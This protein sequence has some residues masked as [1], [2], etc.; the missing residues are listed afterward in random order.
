M[1]G[2]EKI[3]DR[4][5]RYVEGQKYEITWNLQGIKIKFIYSEQ[6]ACGKK[7][8]KQKTN[9]KKKQKNT[10][11]RRDEQDRTLE[12]LQGSQC[13]WSNLQSW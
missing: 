7:K 3:P 8:T 2:K 6:S 10:T 12:R 4:E 5:D 1:E 9:K 13:K 11:T